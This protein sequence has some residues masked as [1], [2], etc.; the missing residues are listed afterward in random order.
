M[1]LRLDPERP[2]GTEV[3][4]GAD[5]DSASASAAAAAAGPSAP[6]SPL[7]ELLEQECL[8][9][10]REAREEEDHVDANTLWRRE[11]AQQRMHTKPTPMPPQPPH[12]TTTMSAPLVA[13]SNSPP[14]LP[15]L[16]VPPSAM[17]FDLPRLD[18]HMHMHATAPVDVGADQFLQR[19]E[20]AVH[21]Y[22]VENEHQRKHHWHLSSASGDRNMLRPLGQHAIAPHLFEQR[23]REEAVR[24][25]SNA[26]NING[27]ATERVVQSKLKQREREHAAATLQKTAAA[28]AALT[29]LPPLPAPSANL[30]L[31]RALAEQVGQTEAKHHEVQ[32][33]LMME[34]EARGCRGSAAAAARRSQGDFDDEADEEAHA[35]EEEEQLFSQ[36][37]PPSG[38]ELCKQQRNNACAEARG[39]ICVLCLMCLR[40]LCVCVCVC[41][42][43]C[44][45]SAVVL[46]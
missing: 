34:D 15:L 2:L 36:A 28:A 4:C 3:P 30:T 33:Q 29:M 14:L 38:A 8:A 13:Q 39:S 32:R 5:R 43:V 44:L 42:C 17:H 23:R 22:A 16:L 11:L 6:A 12:L 26:R 46:R 7:P 40:D 19:L 10:D 9:K 37:P 25:G 41:V 45:I 35:R 1:S 21:T 24:A 18:E 31:F 20:E 27:T